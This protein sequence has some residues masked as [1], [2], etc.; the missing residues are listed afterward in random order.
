VAPRE[1]R[2]A[3]AAAEK[4]ST[5]AGCYN[6]LCGAAGPRAAAAVLLE[7]SKAAQPRRRRR[8]RRLE[9]CEGLRRSKAKVLLRRT[10]LRLLLLLLLRLLL[11]RRLLLRRLL[12]PAQR[13][14]SSTCRSGAAAPADQVQQHLQRSAGASPVRAPVLRLRMDDA[15]LHTPSAVQVALVESLHEAISTGDADALEEGCKAICK[16]LADGYDDIILALIEAGAFT[17]LVE[18]IREA[19]RVTRSRG[20][21]G[22]CLPRL[23]EPSRRRRDRFCVRG[24]RRDQAGDSK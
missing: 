23:V 15:G 20:R 3:S 6:A 21:P 9:G 7:A 14:S 12:R 19:T 1:P 5:I 22:A 24:R 4:L 10:R 2:A 11:L 18:A 8:L 17:A 13:R 16:L